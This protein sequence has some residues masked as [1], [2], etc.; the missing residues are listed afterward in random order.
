MEGLKLQKARKLLGIKVGATEAELRVALRA[1]AARLPFKHP[2]APKRSIK[3]FRDLQE[4]YGVVLHTHAL[5]ENQFVGSPGRNSNP[6]LTEMALKGLSEA[7]SLLYQGNNKEG[8]KWKPGFKVGAWLSRLRCFPQARLQALLDHATSPSQQPCHITARGGKCIQVEAFWH[9]M[10]IWP[11]ERPICFERAAVLS[12]ALEDLKRMATVFE[13]CGASQREAIRKAACLVQQHTPL[14][15]SAELNC[16]GMKNLMTPLSCGVEL[17]QEHAHVLND[18][19]R[20]QEAKGVHKLLLEKQSDLRNAMTFVQKRPE[21]VLT[22]LIKELK[23]ELCRRRLRVRLYCKQPRHLP[24]QGADRKRAECPILLSVEG[25]SPCKRA[26]SMSKDAVQNLE[27]KAVVRLASPSHSCYVPR[28]SFDYNLGDGECVICLDKLS[29]QSL[30][31]GLCGHIFHQSCISR[32]WRCP[33]CRSPLGVGPQ[34]PRCRKT[35]TEEPPLQYVD[36][37][38]QVGGKRSRIRTLEY[39]RGERVIYHRPSGSTLPT[40]CG[41]MIRG[42]C[43]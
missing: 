34:L 19:S 12:E 21:D 23:L 10:H 38:K 16:K 3:E 35:K 41:V 43:L 1:V 33:I 8:V 22:K 6:H 11:V 42:S 26:R 13:K 40:A 28:S 14:C 37:P 15:A 4:A 31:W 7:T 20:A 18:V 27:R 17:A 29:T 2:K 24:D 5:P 25:V 36:I 30:S 9:G 32:A 39:W